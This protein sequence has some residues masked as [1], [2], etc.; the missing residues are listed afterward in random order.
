MVHG[1]RQL[2]AIPSGR[3]VT[4]LRELTLRTAIR[5]SMAGTL[6]EGWLYLS[7][8]TGLTPDTTSLFV[9]SELAA[10][11]GDTGVP[12]LA[13]QRGFPIEGLDSDTIRET[14]QWAQQFSNPPSDALLVESFS[15]YLRFDAFLPQ[16]G[17]PDPPPAEEIRRN[18]DREFIASLGEERIDVACR[19]PSCTSGAIA[20]SA[21]CRRHHFEVVMRRSFPG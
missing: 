3:F 6:G 14:A 20:L 13:V 16:P 5:E 12:T 4:N 1:A 8:S 9:S 11:L 19:A 18:R 17:A 2:S 7:R 21:F 15:Y 10:P